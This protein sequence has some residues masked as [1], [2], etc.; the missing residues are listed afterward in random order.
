MSIAAELKMQEVTDLICLLQLH[1]AQDALWHP[2]DIKSCIIID[3][4][5][6]AIQEVDK[7]VWY[8]WVEAA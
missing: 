3:F 7:C 4:T 5:N 8:E 1:E 2:D 6:S